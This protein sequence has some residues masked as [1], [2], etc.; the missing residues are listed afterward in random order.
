M[1]YTLNKEMLGSFPIVHELVISGESGYR[2]T[3]TELISITMVRYTFYN[4]FIPLILARWKV[5][6]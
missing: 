5:L 3:K 1:D 2:L 4:S 6:F